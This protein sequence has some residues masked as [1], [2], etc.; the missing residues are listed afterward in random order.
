MSE[1]SRIVNPKEK[2]RLDKYLYKAGIGVSRSQI[3]RLIEEGQVL[4]NGQKAKSH[5]PLNRGDKVD[6]NYAKPEGFKVTPEPIE[7][8][9]VYEDQDIIVINKPPV[10]VTHPAPGHL[11][12]T[13]VNAL[14]HH[15]DLSKVSDR[16]R[17]GVLHRLDKDTS[18]LIIFAKTE[19]ALVK[20][21]RQI[22]E[23]KIRR[24]YIAFVWGKMGML[25]GTIDAPIGRHTLDRKHMAVTPLK[26]R[27]AITHFRVLD[28]FKYITH[29]SVELKTGRTHQIRVHLLHFGHPVVGDPDYDGRKKP[30]EVPTPIFDKILTIITRQALHAGELAFM[31]PITKKQMEF[32]SPLPKDM[33]ELLNYLM[34]L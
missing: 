26:S 32:H 33:Q 3:Q 30:I 31:H 11:H 1:F 15:C 18:G 20:L 34:R 27:D 9:I 5:T 19:I 17:P 22:E 10:I 6:V 29:L 8:D 25:E 23:R 24:K 2:I 28:E 14:L 4:V 13:L 21:A 16:T 12:G 7:L